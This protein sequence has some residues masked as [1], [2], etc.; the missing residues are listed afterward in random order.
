VNGI[1]ANHDWS[2]AGE[3][4]RADVSASTFEPVLSYNFDSGWYIDFDSTMTA[5]WKAPS[6]KRWTV[7]V[8]IDAGKTFPLGKKSLSLQFGTYYNV[9]RAEGV[10]EWL[11]RFQAS[12]VL[13]EHG[14]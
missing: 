3:S 8:G 14:P 11:L 12:L 7:P 1:L 13:P 9:V 10:G 5:D 2:F 4:D 6:D